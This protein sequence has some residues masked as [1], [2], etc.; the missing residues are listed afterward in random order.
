MRE[1]RLNK[2]IPR[3]DNNG[4]PDQYQTTEAVIV[5]RQK[6]N[7]RGTRGYPLTIVAPVV[8]GNSALSL[9]W[10]TV[11]QLLDDAAALAML[12]VLLVESEAQNE[13]A[14]DK[15]A[16]ES[17]L[18]PASFKR[19]Q[20]LTLGDA[21]PSL[22]DNPLE[23]LP[24]GWLSIYT[25]D[26]GDT[27]AV[28]ESPVGTSFFRRADG[29]GEPGPEDEISTSRELPGADAIL[30]EH[31]YF[32]AEKVAVGQQTNPDNVDRGSEDWPRD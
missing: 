27:L 10:I 12:G 11:P 25:A 19:E 24:I 31:G 29:W 23:S 14:A 21:F 8:N 17:E 4:K 2:P 7:I 26:N 13:Q 22:K 9:A 5:M 18:I 32:L 30:R 3:D 28:L 6:D 20:W 1:F 15:A 16:T